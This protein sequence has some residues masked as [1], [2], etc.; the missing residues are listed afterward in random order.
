MESLRVLE[1]EFAELDEEYGCS[2]ELSVCEGIDSSAGTSESPSCA[3]NATSTTS[4]EFIGG[5][6]VDLEQTLCDTQEQQDIETFLSTTCK[7][8]LGPEG[9]P[10]CLSLTMDTITRCR[11][12]CAELSH[13]ELDLVVMS[14]VHYLRTV[15]Q[16]PIQKASSIS[17]ANA[18]RPVSSYHI[19]GVKICQATFLFLHGIS[20]N[21]YLRIVTLYDN[22]GLTT[23]VHGNAGRL[24]KNACSLQ[25]VEAVKT[26]IENYARAHG[27]PVPGR[28]PNARDKVMLLPSDMSKMFVYRKYKEALSNPVGKSKFVMLWDELTP[29][30]AV[31]KP[32]SDLC[33]TCQQNNQLIMKSVNMPEAIRRQRLEDASRHLEC[34]R[35]ERH[36]YRSQCEEAETV[37]TA[38]C[39]T[40]EP[41]STM[42]YSYDF[43]QQV[44]FP[45][46]C[47]QTG[48]AY[49][50]T[51][52]KCG[53]FGV[54]C[55]GKSEQVNYL[56]DEDENPG[57]G[58]DCT[59]SLVHHYLD[60]HG[61]GEENV[62]FHADNCT[63]QNKNNANI[64][65]LLWRVMT[66]KHKTAMLSFMLVGHTKFAPD[67]FFGLFK[68]RFRRSC[69]DTMIEVARVV[70]E[71]TITGKNK[72]QLISNLQGE[73]EVQFYQWT[74]YLQQF[75]KPIPNIL[76]YHCF[77]VDVT[78]PGVVMVKEYS[79]SDELSINILKVDPEVVSATGMPQLTQIKGLDPQRQWYLFEQIR[80][81]CKSN[82]TA[83]ITCPQPNFPKPATKVAQPTSKE[84]QAASTST[85]QTP[86][87]LYSPTKKGTKRKCSKC[88]QPGHT[89]RTC[90]ESGP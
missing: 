12:K 77:R 22:E 80:P 64:Q 39:E 25:Q 58:A 51:A 19:H 7:C 88:H 53:I 50:K 9:K 18:F 63:G 21:R 40:H 32:S 5:E 27:L 15:E 68:K 1:S 13:N 45:F 74:A 36:H 56:I 59:I 79:D 46:D 70:E 38:H 85:E 60:K 49:F 34:A 20:R 87:V 48:P 75:F 69:V 83:D 6:V 47:Q 89:K 33:F 73:K 90:T 16:Q 8:K 67:R 52:R 81:F 41:V 57:K 35:S 17:R 2:L 3:E 28:L 82:L 37:W 76:K 66:G 65:Y 61:C 84:A 11:D 29:H 4:G 42:H 71:S 14:Q 55:E 86:P 30:V 44:H 78:K 31:M 72:A 23:S 62:Q 26:F 43:A 10:C 24:P 54:T